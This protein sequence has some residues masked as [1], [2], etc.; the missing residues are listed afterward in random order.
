VTVRRGLAALLALQALAFWLLARTSFFR[1]DDFQYFAEMH[2]SPGRFSE[3]WLTS[4]WFKHM[5]PGHRLMYSLLD[6]ATPGAYRWSLLFEIA[7]MV[8]AALALYGICELLFG[9][10]WWLL[11]PVAVFGFA[12]HF[13]LPLIWPAAGF[14]IMPSAAASL[15]CLYGYLRFVRDR[16]WPWLAV[17]VL[18]LSL[19]LCFYVRPL[20][21]LPL[22]LALRILFLAPSLRP[23]ALARDLRREWPAW[24]AL[25]APA[26]IY[27]F[28]YLHR[29][30]FGHSP[31]L[32]FDEV[33][34]YVRTAW[35]RNV[36]P[37][38][39]GGRLPAGSLSARHVAFEVLAQVLLVALI[40][41]SLWRKG[42]AALRGWAFVLIAVALTFAL[43]A[44]GKLE[45]SRVAEVG[46]DSRYVTDLMWLIPLGV[47][48]ALQPRRVAV[49]GAEWP[50]AEP[51][52]PY[53]APLARLLV[54][55]TVAGLVGAAVLAVTLIQL[56][57]R[58][59]VADEWQAR[60]GRQW[61][62]R[63]RESAAVLAGDGH[64]VRIPDGLVP[65]SVS[66]PSFV[67]AYSFRSVILPLIK[68][69]VDVGTPATG[70]QLGDGTVVGARVVPRATLAVASATGLTGLRSVGGCL[71]A[72]PGAEGIVDWP[73][74][75]PV[76][77]LAVSVGLQDALRVPKAGIGV[78]VDS[79]FGLPAAP[80]RTLPAAAPSTVD[81]GETTVV[82]LR[83]HVPAGGRLCARSAVV[84]ALEQSRG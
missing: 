44:K 36:G 35:L 72:A 79:G 43:T 7:L 11:V 23:G 50:T 9:R 4:I 19:G 82:R 52:R 40:A 22:L 25:A 28:I 60:D 27:T 6:F 84:S 62:L 78:D 75:K 26:L 59:T 77:G 48:M 68:A 39:L 31:P 65:A 3:E 70:A 5:A 81:T 74:P 21:V 32:T 16:S 53:P 46:F 67:A 63:A 12:H 45:P 15:A 1:Q 18:A 83:F 71:V 80:Q 41:L 38:L 24:V 14:Q 34:Q 37:S 61:V 2:R 47:T 55:R 69:P 56:H 30:A 66:D 29:D 64:R 13:A 76:S 42:L 17:G 49:L 54:P 57:A 58:D 10:S 51:L 20:L 8:I 73:L 33:Q